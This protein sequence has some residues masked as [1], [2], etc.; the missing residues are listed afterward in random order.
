MASQDKKGAYGIFQILLERM[1][2]LGSI[3]A[4]TNSVEQKNHSWSFCNILNHTTNLTSFMKGEHCQ[5]GHK[6]RAKS[7]FQFPR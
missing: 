7:F 3:P 5:L 1:I 2:R 6:S 4:L